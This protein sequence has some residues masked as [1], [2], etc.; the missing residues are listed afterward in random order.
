MSTHFLIGKCGGAIL[1]RKTTPE[2]SGFQ[3]VFI[4]EM[5]LADMLETVGLTAL[6]QRYFVA[7]EHDKSLKK[8][9]Y[10]SI[11]MLK[12]N[13]KRVFDSFFC[14]PLRIRPC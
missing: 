7:L 12:N 2:T 10:C 5:G 1:L 11:S 4:G 6:R 14:N 8:R 9:K 3:Y 13:R